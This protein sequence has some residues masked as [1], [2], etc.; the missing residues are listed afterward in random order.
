MKKYLSVL[1]PAIRGTI[2]RLLLLLAVM[3]AAEAALYFLAL[4]RSG[5]AGSI[6]LEELISAS[7]IPL[8]C[9]IFFLLLCALL[10]ASGRD[11]GVRHCYTLCRLPVSEETT[12][13]LW[14]A[15]YAAC[16]VIFWAVQLAVILA[17]CSHYASAAPADYVGRQTVFLA[18]YRHDF[19]HSLLPLDEASR[20]IRNIA[21]ALGLGAGCSF[22]SYLQRRGERSV[23]PFLPAALVL[24][25]FP[26]GMGTFGADCLLTLFS[27]VIITYA[28]AKVWGGRKDEI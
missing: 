26:A 15:Y 21:L 28:A 9:G 14:A 17:L 6:S 16:F 18:F 13:L 27:V 10:A 4:I 23:I 25:F 5:G 8:A 11:S 3:T 20:Y 19:L 22:F 7:H 12:V 1:L 2:F 24:Y